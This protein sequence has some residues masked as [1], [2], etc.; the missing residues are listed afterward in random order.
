MRSALRFL[1]LLV[2]RTVSRL[3]FRFRV[4]WVGKPP[5]DPWSGLRLIAILNHTSL[6]EPVFS[7][8]VPS[9]L[10]WRLARDG[11]IPVADKTVER[12][13]VGWFFRFA[14]GRVVAVSRKRDAT[15][16]E[17]LRQFRDP[18]AMT[19]ICPE[20]RMLRR[21]GFDAEGMPMTV[22]GG[23]AELLAGLRTGGML[24]V[25]SGG[26]HHIAAPGEGMPR[27]FRKVSVR[28]EVL[29]IPEYHAALGGTD[30]PE[31]F[32]RR[33]VADLTERRN[34]YC[35]VTGTTVPRW[36]A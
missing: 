5:D 12:P 28:L 10:L 17:G 35:P 7:A 19:V 1:L 18:R 3:C 13:A 32:R 9:R 6:Y 22:R 14:G 29:E 23:V 11:V 20:G 36:V 33:V 4:E 24:L 25:Y 27:L 31:A 15:W 2:V 30:D 16:Q 34:R 26:L 21:D 8:L